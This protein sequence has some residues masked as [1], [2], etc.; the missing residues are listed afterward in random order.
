VKVTYYKT[1]IEL[2]ELSPRLRH[3]EASTAVLLQQSTELNIR[4][5]RGF[6]QPD[7]IGCQDERPTRGVLPTN[8]TTAGLILRQQG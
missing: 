1:L 8:S 6:T 5:S 3:S 2:T 7:N 4:V